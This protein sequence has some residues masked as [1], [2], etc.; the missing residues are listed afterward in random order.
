MKC[1]LFHACVKDQCKTFS[2]FLGY[3]WYVLNTCNEMRKLFINSF[4][5]LL[6][7]AEQTKYKVETW[8]ATHSEHEKSTIFLSWTKDKPNYLLV[9]YIFKSFL[10]V[11]V[12]MAHYYLEVQCYL[13]NSK[14]GNSA[15]T[16]LD[17]LAQKGGI[18]FLF[19]FWF[20][21]PNS[22]IEIHDCS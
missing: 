18:I 16:N 5:N 20:W 4:I 19:L 2:D 10:T 8:T 13:V 17:F 6:T 7:L 22:L 1:L 3:A 21:S 9:K 12:C 14:V 15:V 11:W